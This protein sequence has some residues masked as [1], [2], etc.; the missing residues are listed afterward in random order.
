MAEYVTLVGVV[1]L[2]CILMMV[3]AG[4]QLVESYQLTRNLIASPFP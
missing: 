4:L 3:W 2:P 1:A